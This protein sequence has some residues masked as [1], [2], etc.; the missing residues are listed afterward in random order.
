[1]RRLGTQKTAQLF[2]RGTTKHFLMR[3]EK[4]L[5]ELRSLQIW[6]DN[7]G[8]GNLKGWYCQQIVV[9]RVD[10]GRRWFFPVNDYLDAARSDGKCERL[11][12][13]SDPDDGVNFNNLFI[14]TVSTKLTD[15]HMWISVFYRPNKSSFSR[16]ARWCCCIGFA[17]L[18]MLA[19][20][21]FDGQGIL[22]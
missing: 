13:P 8:Q 22:N 20:I 5:G 12:P 11:C 4:D 21:M 10:T 18:T 6:H 7:S 14:S 19:N 15:D 17:F 2:D 3:A 9:S 1:M 16:I